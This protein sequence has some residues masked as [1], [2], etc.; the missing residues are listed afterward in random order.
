[1]THQLIP[2]T[3]SILT[4]EAEQLKTEMEVCLNK[5]LSDNPTIADNIGSHMQIAFEYS[6][7]LVNENTRLKAQLYRLPILGKENAHLETKI[8]QYIRERD[9]HQTKI[10][11]LQ[12][13]IEMLKSRNEALNK[14]NNDYELLNGN[15]QSELEKLKQPLRNTEQLPVYDANWLANVVN[16]YDDIYW[17]D[18]ANV[19]VGGIALSSKDS[20]NIIVAALAKK[21]NPLFEASDSKWFI[22]SNAT[23]LVVYDTQYSDGGTLF[24]SKQSAQKAIDILTQHFPE[25]LKNYFV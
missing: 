14:L 10:A 20:T 2:N 5:K 11:E 7:E 22:A 6:K 1:M 15:L 9:R 17:L 16:N 13:E 12:A 18:G 3:Y 23:G 19:R 25:V 24:T 8:D 21:F 4:P